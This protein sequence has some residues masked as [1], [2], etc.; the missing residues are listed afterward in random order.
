MK[1]IFLLA[2]LLN[3]ACSTT[4]PARRASFEVLWARSTTAKE[5]KGFRHAQRTAPVFLDDRIYQ[6]N[7]IDGLVVFNADNGNEIWRLPIRNGIESGVAV[8][9][10]QLF[11][12]ASDGQFYSVDKRT[13][14]VIWN[15]PTRVENLAAPLVNLGVVYFLSG[16]NV[17]YALDSK[18]GKQLWVYNRGEA[19]QLSIRG[20]TRPTLYKG[21]LY[22][23]FS[24]GFLVSLNA[25]DGSIVWERKLNN[26]VKF[27]D[28]DATPIVDEDTIWVS[29][30][31][32]SLFCLSRS[33]GQIQWR[34][35]EGGA[36]AVNVDGDTLY[37]GSLSQGVY[38]L[39]KKTGQQKWRY[40]YPEH[41]GVPTQPVLFRNM[42]LVGT[43]SGAI[44]ALGAQSGKLLTQYFPGTGVF[45]TPAIDPKKNRVFIFSNEANLF[46]LDLDW[47]HPFNQEDWAGRIMQKGL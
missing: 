9:G 35:D 44:M 13:G 8:D 23:G 15:F 38:A 42:V 7:G 37:Y 17:L 33:E 43:S 45:A 5:H 3:A 24:D 32:G 46:A 26:N 19:S 34:L 25:A 39:N 20:G 6:G 1:K 47:R 41:L 12:G 10:D 21:H 29:S 22:V 14:K 36:V 11:F 40:T 27:V 18:T 4:P 16:N 31:D 30:Y 28:V 2:V